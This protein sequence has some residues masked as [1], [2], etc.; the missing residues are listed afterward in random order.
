V[1]ERGEAV[2]GVVL[3]IEGTTTPVSFVYDV[4]FPYARGRLR[5]FLREHFASNDLRDALSSLRD[6]SSKD[7]AGDDRPP[8]WRDEPDAVGAYLEWLMDRDRKSTGLKIIQGLIWERGFHDGTLRGEVYDDVPRALE[9]WRSGGRVIAIYSSGSV[10]AQRL[11]F[12]HST[13]G[14]LTRFIHCYFDTTVGQKRSADSY[15][16]IAKVMDQAPGDLLFVSDVQ[17]ELDA[18]REA[19]MRTALCDRSEKPNGGQAIRSFDEL[20]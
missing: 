1:S 15:R 4:L 11:L 20:A 17:Q 2:T 3:D 10:L 19:G 7:A 18:A 9:R 6:E 16:R 12:R 8:E 5:S 13:A 14:D